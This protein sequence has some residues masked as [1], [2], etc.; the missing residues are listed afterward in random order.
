M[1]T[2]EVQSLSIHSLKIFV[3][4]AGEQWRSQ[5]RAFQGGRAAH[6]KD[7]IEEENEEKLRKNGRK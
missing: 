2:L 5:G 3:P 1:P 4:H 6:L 7:Q